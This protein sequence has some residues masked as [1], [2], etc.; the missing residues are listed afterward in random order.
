MLWNNQQLNIT[1]HKNV[2][3]VANVY[4]YLYLYICHWPHMFS[5]VFF[6]SSFYFD[7]ANMK[8]FRNYLE[9]TNHTNTTGR[10]DCWLCGHQLTIYLSC[11]SIN[12]LSSTCAL[13]NY[14]R[15]VI[16]DVFFSFCLLSPNRTDLEDSGMFGVSLFLF[17]SEWKDSFIFSGCG[18]GLHRFRFRLHFVWIGANLGSVT[19][20]LANPKVINRQNEE[21]HAG[22]IFNHKM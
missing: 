16:F 19:S 15:V 13:P 4:I 18:V 11:A 22:F 7:V 10:N 1:K 14:F 8:V 5:S 20:T 17:F 2:L 12:S 9:T 21:I 3:F 6:F